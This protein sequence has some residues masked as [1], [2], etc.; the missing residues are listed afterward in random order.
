[1]RAVTLVLLAAATVAAAGPAPTSGVVGIYS[2]VERVEFE[3]NAQAPQR[4]RI[5]GAFAFANG[6]LNVPSALSPAKRG[7]MYFRLP[8]VQG[9]VTQT[10]LDAM[11]K[12][13][14]DI[15]SVAGTGQAIGFGNWFYFGS[16]DVFRESM[17]GNSSAQ[18]A[19]VSDGS[20]T[21]VQLRVRPT[22]EAPTLPTTYLTNVGVV[23]L[24]ESGGHATVIGQLRAALRTND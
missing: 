13:W 1:M 6:D 23:K 5:Y 7:Y 22:G 21:A 10:Q 14:N 19:N 4:I 9:R 11:K 15:K 2:I 17:M 18:T 8:T 24:L 3:P 20:A 12:E 16:F